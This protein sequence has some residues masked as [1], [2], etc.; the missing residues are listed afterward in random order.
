MQA[1]ILSL[2]PQP[3]GWIKLFK[4]SEVVAYQKGKEVQT[5]IY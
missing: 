4:K 5:N 1:H 3:V 2:H